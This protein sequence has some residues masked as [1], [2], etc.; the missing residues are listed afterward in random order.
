[1][2]HEL[3]RVLA[4]LF[5]ELGERAAQLLFYENEGAPLWWSAE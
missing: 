3:I 1:V 5:I 4:E 2:T